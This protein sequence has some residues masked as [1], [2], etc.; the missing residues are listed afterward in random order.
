MLNKILLSE[1]EFFIKKLH[2]L[3]EIKKKSMLKQTLYTYA[4]YLHKY[5][6]NNNYIS[7]KNNLLFYKEWNKKEIKIF[8]KILLFII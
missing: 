2:Y 3:E 8:V 6:N 1:K 7:K 5:I 4:M